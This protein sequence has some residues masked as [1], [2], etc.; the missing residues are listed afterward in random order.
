MMLL[1]VDTSTSQ[2]GVAL[3]DGNRVSAESVW[4][5]QH[6]HTIELA[7]AVSELLRHTGISAGDIDG[8]VVAIGPGSFTALRVG[9]ALVKGFAVARKVP[10]VGV[11]T[12]DVIA[13]AQTPSS[14]PLA[15]VLQSG[16]GRLALGWYR[17]ADGSGPGR[18][19]S[20]N[21]DDLGWESQGD[22][23]ITTADA[24]AKSIDSPT[25][26]AGEL[27]AEER[28]RLA[29]KRVNVMLAPPALCVRRPALLAELGRGR[30][31]RGDWDNPATLAPIYLQLN[32]P[33]RA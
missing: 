1:A 6:H 10:L 2:M 14:R 5:S 27:S 22:G 7:P 13:A 23:E 28:Q 18:T 4:Y 8:L 33:L 20:V 19:V 26:I 15:A 3:S 31:D 29:R 32:Q 25:L 16:R 12:L 17:P 30:H 21:S 11:P 24:L 9:L